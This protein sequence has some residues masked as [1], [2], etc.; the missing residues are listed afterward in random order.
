MASEWIYYYNY[1]SEN[2]FPESL[3]FTVDS[4]VLICR[5]RNTGD[6]GTSTTFVNLLLRSIK[7][8]FPKISGY[9]SPFYFKLFLYKLKIFKSNLADFILIN[10]T[11][12]LNFL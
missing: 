1:T 5:D 12:M 10:L 2:S 9:L 7:E 4:V 3:F 11:S 8:K 6:N